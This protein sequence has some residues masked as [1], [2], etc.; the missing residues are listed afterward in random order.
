MTLTL[1]SLYAHHVLYFPNPDETRLKILSH[2]E[3]IKNGPRGPGAPLKPTND[4]FRGYLVILGPILFDWA[5]CVKY[6]RVRY[7]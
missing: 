7:P 6:G 5:D 2:L 3:H 1:K 4:H